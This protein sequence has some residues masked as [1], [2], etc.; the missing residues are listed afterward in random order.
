MSYQDW[1]ESMIVKNKPKAKSRQEKGGGPKTAEAKK[2]PKAPKNLD[3]VK[4]D[5]SF[6]HKQIGMTFRKSLQQARVAK[7]WKQ[8]QLAKALN[9]NKQI[10]AQYEAGK[11][12]PLFF[13]S[14]SNFITNL[15]FPKQPYPT[16]ASFLR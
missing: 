13:Y 9:I 8:D 3:E 16:P 4:D 11:G 1:G 5:E 15:L 6:R 12:N 7:G 10:V 14:F 2:K